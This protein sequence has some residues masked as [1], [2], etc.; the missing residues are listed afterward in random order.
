[1]VIIQ[2]IF[3]GERELFKGETYPWEC[4]PGPCGGKQG[5]GHSVGRR[6]KP[7]RVERAEE[8]GQWWEP[9]WWMEG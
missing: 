6:R 9:E 7:G 5:R 3:E 8:A 1:M 4:Q 2:L